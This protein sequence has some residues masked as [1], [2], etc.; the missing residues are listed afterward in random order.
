MLRK[1]SI[2]RGPPSREALE[3]PR[4]Q[5]QLIHYSQGE[6]HEKNLWCQAGLSLGLVGVPLSLVHSSKDGLVLMLS[7]RGGQGTG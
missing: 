1:S 5:K 3:T 7:K 2:K 4:S 6:T